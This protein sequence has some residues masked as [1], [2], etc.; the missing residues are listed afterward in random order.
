MRDSARR[1]R[2]GALA[3]LVGVV[4]GAIAISGSGHAADPEGAEREAVVAAVDGLFDAMRAKDA[5]AM[6][7]LFAPEISMA[8]V[9]SDGRSRV[10]VGPPDGFIG[11][12][13]G[14]EAFLD[15]V[16]WDPL[17]RVD[18]ALAML[19]APYDFLLDGQPSH[20]GFNAFHLVKMD[21]RWRIVAVA[22]SRR[23]EGCDEIGAFQREPAEPE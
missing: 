17:V 23:S 10:S 3:G 5:E 1:A 14:S 13:T 20:C 22:F 9:G 18:G 21:E 4:I 12:I 7:E 8:A 15:E 11:S 16:M 19:W 6:R 2:S